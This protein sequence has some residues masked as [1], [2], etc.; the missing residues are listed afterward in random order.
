MANLG[1]SRPNATIYMA[2][3]DGP[4]IYYTIDGEVQTPIEE[5]EA[6]Q[7]INAG[8]ARLDDSGVI[9]WYGI[10]NGLYSDDPL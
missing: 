9:D 5:A 6:W 10:S 4:L 1:D 8:H 3:P 2:N 7:R